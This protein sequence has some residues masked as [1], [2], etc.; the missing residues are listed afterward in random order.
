MF[1]DEEIKEIK[2]YIEN[3]TSK[4][5]IYVGTDS[6]KLKHSR[7]RYATVIVIHYDGHCGAKIFGTVSIEKDI[8]EKKNRPFMRMMN[9]VYKTSDVYLKIVDSIGSRY[10]EIHLD[11]NPDENYGS[12]IA[13]TSAVGYIKGVLGVTPITKPAERSF[14]ASCVADKWCKG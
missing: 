10:S 6:Q 1:T 5:K 12:N 7:T 8:K 13:L 4:T 2:K 14:A 11:I 3:T 9:E